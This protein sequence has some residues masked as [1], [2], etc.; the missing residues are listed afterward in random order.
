MI[1]NLQW[2]ELKA[3]H[4]INIYKQEMSNDPYAPL[5]PSVEKGLW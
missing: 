2:N 4:K 3:S 5:A 1:V